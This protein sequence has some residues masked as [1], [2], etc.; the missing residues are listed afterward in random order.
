MI[1]VCFALCSVFCFLETVVLSAEDLELNSQPINSMDGFCGAF[2]LQ[3][4]MRSHGMEIDIF[5]IMSNSKNENGLTTLSMLDLK[6]VAESRSLKCTVVR[7]RGLAIPN[8]PN[9]MIASI[10]PKANNLDG[11]FVVIFPRKN[12][13]LVWDPAVL[14]SDRQARMLAP[15]VKSDLAGDFL[16]CANYESIDVASITTTNG[17]A[18]S[19]L[20]S[21][22]VALIVFFT[23][24]WFCRTVSN[25]VYVPSRGLTATDGSVKV[26]SDTL[27][28]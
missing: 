23:C 12:M 1:W 27:S 13:L 9:P 24:I 17:V 15:L 16:L 5:D 3:E 11:H 10:K 25:M 21:L 2:A 7:T 18:N 26:L 28:T 20:Y 14:G 19:T 8:W 6:K 22:L 4:V